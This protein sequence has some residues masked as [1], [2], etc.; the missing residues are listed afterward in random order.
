MT[1]RAT[2]CQVPQDHPPCHSSCSA[3]VITIGQSFSL[4]WGARP[5][6]LLHFLCIRVMAA[7]VVTYDTSSFGSARY[8]VGPLSHVRIRVSAR[9]SASESAMGRD[10]ASGRTGGTPADGRCA[11]PSI[12][13]P[14]WL[15]PHRSLLA[16][17]AAPRSGRIRAQ[18]VRLRSADFTTPPVLAS[19]CSGSS[20]WPDP[21]PSGATA[22]CR[23]RD[24][25][26]NLSAVRRDLALPAGRLPNSASAQ[27]PPRTLGPGGRSGRGSSPAG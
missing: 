3:G 15:P 11:L 4:R 6:A 26:S 25:A 12:C 7:A 8:R 27:P 18:V 16:V 20:Q 19:G 22:Q 10:P 21:G 17:A 9:A 14:F 5:T 2:K 23:L 13:L 1:H 24:S